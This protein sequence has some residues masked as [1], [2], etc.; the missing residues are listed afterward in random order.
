MI[1]THVLYMY[2]YTYIH[3]DPGGLAAHSVDV[4]V[5]SPIILLKPKH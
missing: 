4:G 2:I 1:V 3:T 5:T